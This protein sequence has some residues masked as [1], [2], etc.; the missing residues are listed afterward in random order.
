MSKRKK[1]EYIRP[2]NYTITAMDLK[3]LRNE[4]ASWQISHRLVM[5]DLAA[6]R[7]EDF[8]GRVKTNGILEKEQYERKC[9]MQ[10]DALQRQI[11]HLYTIKNKKP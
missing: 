4:L 7:K 9:R 1:A 3:T 5:E 11:T 10:I 6:Y 8:P 2:R